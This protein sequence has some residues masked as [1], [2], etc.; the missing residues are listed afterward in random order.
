MHG[1]L[2]VPD[3]DHADALRRA[4]A[5][6]RLLAGVRGPDPD[7]V[8]ICDERSFATVAGR[9]VPRGPVIIVAGQ[10]DGSSRHE[11]S[12]GARHRVRHAARLARRLD[13]RAVIC[14][15]FCGQGDRSEAR[16][17]ADLLGGC[18]AA[19]LCEE[20]SSATARHAVNCLA[21]LNAIGCMDVVM[22]SSWWHTPRAVA[23]AWLALA[24]HGYRVR[25]GFAPSDDR[26]LFHLAYEL[27]AWRRIAG[28]VRIS[29]GRP[30]YP[31]QAPLV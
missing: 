6:N 10:S 25:G 30:A 22:V 27:G 29:A 19:V 28:D 15:G 17:M 16:Q 21:L 20:A 26:V 9:P 13:A 4:L 1:V 3:R 18:G 23:L 14:S 7:R 12:A 11:L 8:L 2:A 5:A 24:G 31:G